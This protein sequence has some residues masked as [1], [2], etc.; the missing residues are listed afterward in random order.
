MKVIF[1]AKKDSE[2]YFKGN[3]EWVYHL[4]QKKENKTNFV[5]NSLSCDLA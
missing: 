1:R 5:K 2:N 4:V 3:P